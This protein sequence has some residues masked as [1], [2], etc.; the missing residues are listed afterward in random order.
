MHRSVFAFLMILFWAATVSGQERRGVVADSLSRSPLPNASVFDRNGRLAGVCDSHGHLPYVSPSDYPVT[1]R[2]LGFEEKTVLRASADTVFLKESF[3]EL[4]EVVV[5]SRQHKVLHMLAYVREY[6]T[7]TTYTDT[8]FLF[9]EK[10]VD[11]MLNPGN[12]TS[13]KGWTT[14]RVMKTRS[15]YRFTNA[16]GLDS[17]S[18][19]SN[20]HFS[21]SD[22]VG[23]GVDVKI[24]ERL[25]SAEWAT[26]TVRGKYSATEVWLKNRDRFTVDV[27]VLADTTGRKWVPNLRGFFQNG[28]DFENFRAKFTYSNVDG[29]SLKPVDLAGYSFNIE[30]NG[31]GHDMF[32]FH[33]VNEPFFVSTYAEVYI[34]DKEYITVKEAKKWERYKFTDNAVEIYEPVEAPELQPV[35]MALVE[36]V[37]NLDTDEVRLGFDPDPHRIYEKASRRGVNRNFS[38]GHRMLGMLKQLT[39]IGEARANRKMNRDWRNLKKDMREENA[40]RALPTSD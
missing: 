14:P 28:L 39:G 5:E 3:S 10:M 34:L 4:P 36:R 21:W 32:L 1:V 13:F 19:R 25:A 29:D 40:K 27:N 20:H 38:I 8:V 24:P 37:N 31:R 12:K 22:W 35:I 23:I 7:L 2:Y 26:D 33:R 15:Y 6:S 16:E 18:D 30:S 11:Y 9:R 17:V